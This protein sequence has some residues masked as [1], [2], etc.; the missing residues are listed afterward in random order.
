MDYEDLVLEVDGATSDIDMYSSCSGSSGTSL[1]SSLMQ[2]GSQSFVKSYMGSG[3]YVMESEHT[4][5][6]VKK[7]LFLHYLILVQIVD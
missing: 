2:A 5:E 1:A 7:L 6:G 3:E 4:A